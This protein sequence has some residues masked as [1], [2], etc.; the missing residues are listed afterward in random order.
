MSTSNCPKE[1]LSY[2][3]NIINTNNHKITKLPSNKK[4]LQSFRMLAKT[5]K[6]KWWKREKNTLGRN[7]Y[8]VYDTKD[9][10]NLNEINNIL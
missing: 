10:D 5:P 4:N 3:N 7:V 8:K 9:K 6:I 1:N 2:L